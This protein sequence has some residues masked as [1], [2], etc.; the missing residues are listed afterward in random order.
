GH[1]PGN[2]A[3]GSTSILTRRK[4]ER[5]RRG[6]AQIASGEH[7]VLAEYGPRQVERHLAGV[8]LRRDHWVRMQIL[9]QRLMDRQRKNLRVVGAAMAADH[10][11][12]LAVPL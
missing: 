12:G 5:R 11:Q 9:L 4:A 6:F 2:G 7:G 8:A 10:I 3:V 1:R